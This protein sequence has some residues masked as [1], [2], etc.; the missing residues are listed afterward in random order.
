MAKKRAKIRASS[1]IKQASAFVV[2]AQKEQWD[3]SPELLAVVEK[4]AA[5]KKICFVLNATNKDFQ[6]YWNDSPN[7]PWQGQSQCRRVVILWAGVPISP[8]AILSWRC[9]LIEEVDLAYVFLFLPQKDINEWQKWLEDKLGDWA[10]PLPEKERNGLRV[11]ELVYYSKNDDLVELAEY[12]PSF[13]T[14]SP[15]GRMADVLEQLDSCK[16]MYRE[17]VQSKVDHMKEAFHDALEKALAISF[18]Q[19]DQAR[20]TEHKNRTADLQNTIKNP[21]SLV[22]RNLLPKVLLLGPSGVGKTLV[23]RYLAWRTSQ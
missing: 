4:I 16:R 7:K 8:A 17:V 19:D 6:Q 12:D 5:E 13:L 15:S 14:I 21:E 10:K 1:K 9:G 3:F 18:D 2:P 22:D 11:G 20:R 23:A